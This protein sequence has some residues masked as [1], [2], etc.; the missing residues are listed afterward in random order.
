MW[1]PRYLD[2]LERRKRVV[3]LHK[4]V[5]HPSPSSTRFFDP[6]LTG[7]PRTQIRVFFTRRPVGA[8]SCKASFSIDG[9]APTIS[10]A[11][12]TALEISYR[13][14]VYA[15]DA[16]APVQRRISVTNLGQILWLDYIEY[17]IAT[18]FSLASSKRSLTDVVGK[19]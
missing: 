17:T 12:N 15:S 8:Y 9:G 19:G 16:L 11:S 1:T 10:G 6:N 2:K 13:S 18:E 4:S 5:K 14:L 7:A 3:R